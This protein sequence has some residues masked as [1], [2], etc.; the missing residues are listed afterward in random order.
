MIYR[1]HTIICYKLSKIDHAMKA[2]SCK[3]IRKQMK[4]VV[5]SRNN[6]LQQVVCRSRESKNTR[7]VH[8]NKQMKFYRFFHT[9]LI[10]LE[11][12]EFWYLPKIDRKAS[13]T[14]PSLKPSLYHARSTP[15]H[16]TQGALK[17]VTRGS[18]TFLS[19]SKW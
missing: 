5:L 15:D 14:N 12:Q 11:C 16:V 4:L 6:K 1:N 9:L 18:V 3:C 8:Y 7:T 2:T 13:A 19:E 17:C 10:N